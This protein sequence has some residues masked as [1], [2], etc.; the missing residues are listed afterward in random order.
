M[1]PLIFGFDLLD[2]PPVIGW[3]DAARGVNTCPG[4]DLTQHGGSIRIEDEP[5]RL[6]GPGKEGGLSSGEVYR[7]KVIV[8]GLKKLA[9]HGVL[10][11][12]SEILTLDELSALG[13]SFYYDHRN[14]RWRY[15][16]D[17]LETEEEG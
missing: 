17:W 7:R 4:R 14:E 10:Q 1:S 12:I 13:L 2:D 11:T 16:A 8:S 6:I 3:S 15:P 9:D 5:Q